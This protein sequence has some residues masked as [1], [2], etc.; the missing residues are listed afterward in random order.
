MS[1]ILRFTNCSVFF[2][3]R[4]WLRRD[5]FFH[6]PS[7][8]LSFSR[9]F[10][11]SLSLSFSFS[12]VWNQSDPHSGKSYEGKIVIRYNTQFLFPLPYSLFNHKFSIDRFI[13]IRKLCPRIERER[14]NRK[15]SLRS[16]TAFP[17]NRKR[18]EE[19]IAVNGNLTTKVTSASRMGGREWVQFMI[20]NMIEAYTRTKPYNT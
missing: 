17:H 6:F 2:D 14:E 19:K 11:L 8:P 18:K 15:V 1:Q 20:C 16:P 12:P 7:F 5:Q 9:F 13:C 4:I 10:S 3:Q